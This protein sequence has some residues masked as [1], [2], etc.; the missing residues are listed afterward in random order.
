MIF[1]T[2]KVGAI[3]TLIITHTKK[4]KIDVLSL[5]VVVAGEDNLLK[6][7]LAVCV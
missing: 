5:Q 2:F 6:I 4:S 7:K 3:N 1:N